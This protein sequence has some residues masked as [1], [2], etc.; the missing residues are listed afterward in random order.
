MLPVVP[1]KLDN[2]ILNSQTDEFK[3]NSLN[4]NMLSSANVVNNNNNTSQTPQMDYYINK[5]I[6][7][8]QISRLQKMKSFQESCM[9]NI[10]SP[11]LLPITSSSGACTNPISIPALTATTPLVPYKV[12]NST[13][14]ATL[15]SSCIPNSIGNN[16]ISE[17]DSNN[18]FYNV[19]KSGIYRDDTEIIQPM[20]SG[21]NIITKSGILYRDN[22]E[23]IQ[24]VAGG[25]N[26]I[27][28]NIANTTQYFSL[29]L[30]TAK[31]ST[32]QPQ[33]FTTSIVA[34]IVNYRRRRW[35][36]IYGSI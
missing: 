5:S 13:A 3:E 4:Y 28:N 35:R 30:T 9:K 27:A 18:S 2:G 11:L 1:V 8:E 22:T 14:T 36:R 21:N 31:S 25:N 33:T 23:I 17:I 10:E 6:I 32:I 24:P 16:T 7:N 12:A 15:P 20:A 29:P 26:I 34:S 19:T